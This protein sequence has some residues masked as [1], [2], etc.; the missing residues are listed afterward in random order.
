MSISRVAVVGVG[1]MGEAM[2]H[3]LNRIGISHANIT[4]K[5]K[6]TE[7][8]SDLINRLGVK[9]GSISDSQVVLLAVKP[10]DLEMTLKEINLEI[11]EGT[12]LVSILAGIRCSKI[13][14]ILGPKARVVRVMPNTP[15]LMGT[16]M[17][18]MA[19]GKSA[20]YSDIEWVESL[21]SNSGKTLIV[22]ESLMDAVTAT[23]GSGPAYF[24]GF[25]ESMIKAAVKL[26]LSEQDAKLLVH[27]TLIGVAKMIEGS[28]K[29][30]G[31]LRKEVT[32]PNGTTAAALSSFESSGLDEIVYKAMKAAKDRSE[33]LS[34]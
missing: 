27:Q 14:G 24:F 19:S 22:D 12:L 31:T 25:V 5:E 16:G 29:D 32:S 15:L 6:R 13:E 33:E 2:I 23:S 30:A 34:N 17:S 10:Q 1:V 8:E 26:G 21:L 20:T 7:R 9:R 3:S 18:V 11:A 28:G 4:I